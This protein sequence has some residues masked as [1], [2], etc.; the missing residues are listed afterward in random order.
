MAKGFE[1]DAAASQASNENGVRLQN[2][3]LFEDQFG[4]KFEV[5]LT[6]MVAEDDTIGG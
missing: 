2:V 3:S 4:I 5:E 6:L 1:F